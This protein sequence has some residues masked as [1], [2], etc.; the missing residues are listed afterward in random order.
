M[1]NGRKITTKAAFLNGTSLSSISKIGAMVVALGLSAM[2][3][4]PS[5]FADPVTITPHAAFNVTHT[6]NVY[7]TDGGEI[8]D[9]V[10][11]ADLG[12]IINGKLPGLETSLTYTLSYDKYD[13]AS[14]LDGLRHSL[15]SNNTFE[16]AP[17]F[18]YID[19]TGSI[20]ERELDRSTV[21]SATL[22]SYGGEQTRVYTISVS[23]YIQTEI[24]TDIELVARLRASTVSYGETESGSGSAVPNDR[25]IFGAFVSI[26][27]EVATNPLTFRASVSA[28]NYD[29]GRESQEVLGSVFY[30]TSGSLRLIGRVG[31]DRADTNGDGDS[32]I[33]ETMWR[34]GVEYRPTQRS[35]FRAEAGQKYDR[36]TY[37]ME[38]SH[39]F[40][41]NFNLSASY[42]HQ[43][44]T[45]AGRLVIDS[46]SLII[47]ED[48]N[49]I[50]IEDVTT[51]LVD[52]TYISK[53]ATVRANGEFGR[54]SYSA[55]LSYLDRSFEVAADNEEILRVFLRGQLALSERIGLHM[56]ASIS[57]EDA[58]LA[59][60]EIDIT[61]YGG[62]AYFYIT[63]TARV[64]LNI[65]SQSYEY[66][67]GEEI[68]ENAVVLSLA[69]SW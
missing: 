57:D 35:S 58:M 61:R 1:V 3:S 65:V 15:R 40:R 41:D 51:R 33:E 7:L 8:D 46:A 24:G 6:D 22:R 5:A 55:G 10:V 4:A 30:N 60:S 9:T 59:A 42:T 44:Q 27:N 62:G 36:T 67:T 38:A 64:S 23:P 11:S 26:N 29:N 69:K 50:A 25:D 56:S 32:N 19:V 16:L 49:L 45:D 31:Y 68:D 2:A 39:A 18:F 34:A 28:R 63:E 20:Q 48:G 37:D 14:E 66:G 17:D 21:R 12:F 53:R 52:D 54:F 47:D 13:T 43:L